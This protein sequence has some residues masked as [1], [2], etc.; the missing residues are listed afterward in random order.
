MQGID[1]E[2]D[3]RII[4]GGSGR[5][6]CIVSPGASAGDCRYDT[7]ARQIGMEDDIRSVDL[8]PDGKVLALGTMGYEVLFKTVGADVHDVQ[9]VPNSGSPLRGV[10]P[11][12]SPSGDRILVVQ[13][14]RVL[15]FTVGSDAAPV[16]LRPDRRPRAGIFAPDGR[17]VAILDENYGVSVWPADGGPGARTST[18]RSSTTPTRPAHH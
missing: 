14:E 8:S 5:Y 17:H 12:F 2:A 9:L 11:R 1:V 18:G 7:S 6:A 4:L 3:G 15:I 13:T 16:Q 10:R